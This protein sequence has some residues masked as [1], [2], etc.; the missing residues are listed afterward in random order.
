MDVDVHLRQG[1]ADHVGV[2]LLQQFQGMQRDLAR[3]AAPAHAE[4]GG[5]GQA[6]D[7]A[8]VGDRLAPA[9]CRAARGRSPAAASAAAAPS[10]PTSAGRARWPRLCRSG[11][12][13]CRLSCPCGSPRP[14]RPA[15]ADSP[16]GPGMVGVRRRQ[17][18]WRMSQSST[19]TCSPFIAARRPSARV[20][21]VLPSCG[22]AAVTAM[23]C[24]RSG[25]SDR[26]ARSARSCSASAD[27][28]L[29][30]A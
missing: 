4:Q 29:R 18:G 6:G 23:M 20:T 21:V 25:H 11:C 15:P 3:R 19:M 12:S 8:R 26:P 7:D 2:R 24:G 28:G 13:P 22:R 16:P 17:E 9:A 5:I 30:A 10:W 14:A 1:R 27:S